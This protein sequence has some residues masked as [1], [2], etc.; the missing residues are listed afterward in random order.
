VKFKVRQIWVPKELFW[1]S[2]F[3]FWSKIST[4]QSVQ[5]SVAACQVQT[6]YPNEFTLFDS[7]KVWLFQKHD[8]PYYGLLNEAEFRAFVRVTDTLS[9]DKTVYGQFMQYRYSVYRGFQKTRKR[10]KKWQLKEDKLSILWNKRLIY[11]G[12]GVYDIQRIEVPC[13]T[14]KNKYVLR[15]EVLRWHQR[16]YHTGQ[17]QLLEE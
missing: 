13:N 10:V 11:R 15:F 4:A 16:W 5:D 1:I 9:S 6:G 3:I 14:K 2:F 17:I 12:E 7:I 8:Y